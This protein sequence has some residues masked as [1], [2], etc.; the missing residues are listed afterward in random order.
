M[1]SVDKIIGSYLKEISLV[2]TSTEEE[3]LGNTWRDVS[4]NIINTGIAGGRAN[5]VR[6]M[7]ICKDERCKQE[8]DL[9]AT[10]YV[11]G[12]LETGIG[13]CRS[14]KRCVK[15]VL[16][17]IINIAQRADEKVRRYGFGPPYLRD[18]IAFSKRMGFGA[19]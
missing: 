19:K 16:T 18:A 17:R 7:A 6:C 5:K 1:S 2:S 12:R 14:D 9:R 4:N 13:G 3:S 15:S 11:I 8:C 10:T